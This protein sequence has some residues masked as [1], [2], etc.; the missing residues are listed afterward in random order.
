MVS[1]ATLRVKETLKAGDYLL[2][3]VLAGDI[4]RLI[5]YPK[6]KKES[7]WEHWQGG[8]YAERVIAESIGV[9]VMEVG[10]TPLDSSLV[11]C[12]WVKVLSLPKHEIGWVFLDL[13]FWK[14]LSA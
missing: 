5:M 3:T 7:A 11:T 4:S 10:D 9:V 8:Y 12:A 2:D 1:K 14:R 13:N 6:A